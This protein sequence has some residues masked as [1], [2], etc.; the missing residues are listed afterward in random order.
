MSIYVL[1]SFEIFLTENNDLNAQWLDLNS[2]FQT[3]LAMVHLIY[4][5]SF[6]LY[7]LL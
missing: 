2:S 6:F 3:T 5:Q 4:K 1:L 7:I